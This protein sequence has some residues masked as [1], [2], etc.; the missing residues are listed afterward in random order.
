M[1]ALIVPIGK[2]KLNKLISLPLSA[3][4]ENIS[5]EIGRFLVLSEHY[6]TNA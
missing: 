2:L 1:L 6:N 5:L 4:I 3:V